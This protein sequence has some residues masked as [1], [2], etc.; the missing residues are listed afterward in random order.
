MKLNTKMKKLLLCIAVATAMSSCGVQTHAI[1]RE[2]SGRNVEPLQNVVVTPLLADLELINETKQVYTETSDLVVTGV[3]KIEQIDAA[4]NM[5]LLNAAKRY[6]ADTMVAAL[7][8]VDTDDK[9]HLVITVTGYPARYTNF[10]KMTSA[11]AWVSSAML[12]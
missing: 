8:S 2:A 5:A 4:K 9:G 6:D 11:D 12:K 3:T 7:V 10:R 1:Y